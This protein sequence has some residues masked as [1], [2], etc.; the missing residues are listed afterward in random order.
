MNDRNCKYAA[1]SATILLRKKQ[2]HTKKRIDIASVLWY[3]SIRLWKIPG[4][5]SERFKELVL[6]TSD[7]AMCRGFESHSLRHFSFPGANSFDLEWYPRG[8]RGS[9]AKGVGV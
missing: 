1:L 4:E 6:K 3:N 7:T 8:R 5:M 2:N 9:P